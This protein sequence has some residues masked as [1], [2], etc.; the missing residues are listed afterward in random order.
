[1]K[2][3]KSVE[4]R[5]RYGAEFKQKVIRMLVS[6]RS[7][8]ETSEAFGIAENVLYRWRRMA[9]KKTKSNSVESGNDKAAK[10]TAE[11]ARLRAE[12]E[13]LKTDREILKALDI[14]GQSDSGMSMS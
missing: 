1:M 9:T 14:L 2:D 5:Q 6:G 10:L 11:V 8:R 4:T 13:R 7:I 12:N 3:P